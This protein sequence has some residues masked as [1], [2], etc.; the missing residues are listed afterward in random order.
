MAAAAAGTGGGQGREGV[1]GSLAYYRRVGEWV[2]GWV[3]VIG[4]L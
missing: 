3:L 2:D 4:E 1:R